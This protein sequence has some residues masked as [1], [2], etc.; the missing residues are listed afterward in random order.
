MW[1][2]SAPVRTYAEEIA[3][4]FC[5]GHNAAFDFRQDAALD[6][7]DDT[8]PAMARILCDGM[9]QGTERSALDGVS[10]VSAAMPKS[11]SNVSY[12]TPIRPILNYFELM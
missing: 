7:Y 9:R 11:R 8:R 4:A 1:R 6:P 3:E 10:S 2:Y 12:L 5:D